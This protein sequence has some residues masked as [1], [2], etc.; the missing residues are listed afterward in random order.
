MKLRKALALLFSFVLTALSFAQD[1][2]AVTLF[3]GDP[4]P[5]LTVGKWVK[6]APVQRLEKGKLY[7]VEFWATWCIPCRATIPHLTEL[8]K[9]NPEVNFIG[10]S[11]LEEDQKLV[12][13][14]V[15]QMG[16]KMGFNVA[17]D[18]LP[19]A[20]AD[21]F[22]GLMATRWVEAA[23]PLGVPMAFIIDKGGDIAWIGNP[24]EMD[25]PLS[26]VLDGSW[27]TKAYGAAMRAQQELQNRQIAYE[28]R[29]KQ[30]VRA[31]DEAALLKVYDDM[32][33]DALAPIQVNGAIK[34]F[35]YLLVEK[36]DY[37]AAYA[38]GRASLKGPLNDDARRL[39]ELAWL[40]VDPKKSV[41]L[42]DTE[43]A[44]A[45]A[46]RSVELKKG[47]FNLNTLAHGYFF[48][49][50]KAK[51]VDTEKEALARAANDDERKFIQAAIAEFGDS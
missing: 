50:D 18:K 39:E 41:E 13:P 9:K 5:A 3:P 15:K 6:G 20:K 26:K 34:R 36:K 21:G 2:Q 44:I 22:E 16:D 14:F 29:E 30:A 32:I 40:I 27:D 43:L 11:I 37:D 12:A 28:Q 25:E 47:I 7:V 48:A 23:G 1:P 8:A 46:Q 38:S 35:R 51:A 4:A 10:V 49:G 31:K 19:S 42:R 45:A 33:G 24:T 17:M